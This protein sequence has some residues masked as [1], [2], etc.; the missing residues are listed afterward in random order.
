MPVGRRSGNSVNYT[1]VPDDPEIREQFNIDADLKLQNG[2][3]VFDASLYDKQT[4][5]TTVVAITLDP[6]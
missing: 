3:I 4:R 6:V 1:L 2:A 5:N